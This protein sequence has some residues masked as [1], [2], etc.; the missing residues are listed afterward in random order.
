MT[1]WLTRIQLNLR[2]RDARRDVTS[3]VGLHHRLMMLFPDNAGETA[4]QNMGVLFRLEDATNTG[5]QSPY[6]L[7]QSQVQPDLNRLPNGYGTTA[8]KNLTPLIDALRDG[9]P[10][11]YRIAASAVRKSGPTTRAAGAKAIIALH[12]TEADQWWQ[13]QAEHKAGLTLTTTHSTPLDAARGTR[14]QDKHHVK[15]PRTRFE[16]TAVITD[17]DAL[18]QTLLSGVGRGK[19]YGCGLLSIAPA[20]RK[21]R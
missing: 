9:L 6:I 16:G 18:R 17:T 5:P 10:V 2:H 21:P 15:H 3:A 8:S 14:V 20:A 12:G 4:R 19:A 7:I 11:H 13:R 1:V